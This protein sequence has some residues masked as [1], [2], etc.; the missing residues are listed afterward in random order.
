MKYSHVQDLLK[1]A[2]TPPRTGDLRTGQRGIKRLTA[3]RFLDGNIK[4]V[5]FKNFNFHVNQIKPTKYG[6]SLVH[7]EW[8]K[9]TK[10][11]SKLI[12]LSAT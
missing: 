10:V 11:Y 12:T 4:M 2:T 6:I 9:F 3:K 5:D 1:E 7:T 8:M